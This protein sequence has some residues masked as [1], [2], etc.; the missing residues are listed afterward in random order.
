MVLGVRPETI[1]LGEGPLQGRIEDIE[2]HG[3]EALYHLSTPLGAMR[4]LEPGSSA[5]FRTGDSIAF[6]LG[7]T[8]VFDHATGARLDGTGVDPHS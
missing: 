1:R 4:A 2:P 5:R 8:L 7:P 3:R 6:D